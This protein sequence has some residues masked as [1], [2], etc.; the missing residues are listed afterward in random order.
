MGNFN[1]SYGSSDYYR[2]ARQVYVK[3]T[4]VDVLCKEI[5]DRTTN[6]IDF[7]TQNFVTRIEKYFSTGNGYYD[8][9]SLRYFFYEYE[10]KLAEKNNI[11]RRGQRIKLRLMLFTSTRAR[12]NRSWE[13][14]F[15]GSVEMISNPQRYL[16]SLIT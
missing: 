6:D 13:R 14:S 9:N 1:A 3:E 15:S 12:L 5:Y 4:D 2:A 10:A 8:W 11:E 16:F 7:A